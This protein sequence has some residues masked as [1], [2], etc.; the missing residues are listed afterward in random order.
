MKKPPSSPPHQ[1][2][3]KKIQKHK[4]KIHDHKTIQLLTHKILP[5][6]TLQNNHPTT[7]PIIT[8]HTQNDHLQNKIPIQIKNLKT[9][10][11]TKYINPIHL[12]NQ[13]IPNVF[14]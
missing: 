10:K 3:K 11:K 1:L 14:L 8:K 4:N 6:L 2:S 7:Q 9:K 12:L 5:T 13:S